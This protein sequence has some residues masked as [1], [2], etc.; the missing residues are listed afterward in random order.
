VQHLVFFDLMNTISCVYC[1]L[2]H[3]W[4]KMAAAGWNSLE[5]RGIGGI[6]IASE[7]AG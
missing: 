5:Y 3:L 4:D 2:S 1:P 7:N 6:G